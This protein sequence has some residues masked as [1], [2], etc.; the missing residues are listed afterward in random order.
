MFGL[1][2][3][4]YIV[5]NITRHDRARRSEFTVLDRLYTDNNL[6]NFCSYETTFHMSGKVKNHNIKTWGFD[7]NPHFTRSVLE[8][9][10]M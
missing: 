4:G 3:Y 9:V 6:N 8:I 10:R 5:Q 1:K 7:E 2:S